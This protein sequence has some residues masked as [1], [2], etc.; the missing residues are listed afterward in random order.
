MAMSDPTVVLLLLLIS[1]SFTKCKLYG[2][3]R[4]MSSNNTLPDNKDYVVTALMFFTGFSQ[5]AIAALFLTSAVIHTTQG[6]YQF[7]MNSLEAT[8]GIL[9]LD[10]VSVGLIACTPAVRR[11]FK[12]F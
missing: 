12:S 9:L 2:I 7:A 1:Y 4:I 6:R 3:V 10:V 8:A 5:E 11:V